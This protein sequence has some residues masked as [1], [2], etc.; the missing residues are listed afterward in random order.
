MTFQSPFLLAEN[1]PGIP[2]PG[3]VIGTQ[4]PFFIGK[5]IQFK[6]NEEMQ[7]YLSKVTEEQ[8][9]FFQCPGYRIG[10]LINSSLLTRPDTSPSTSY[11]NSMAEFYLHH[12]IN[13]NASYYKKYKE[14]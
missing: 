7:D 9:R 4:P 1:P 11:C 6:T 3:L 13:R 14:A 12:K 2:G 8:S 5:V 10:L